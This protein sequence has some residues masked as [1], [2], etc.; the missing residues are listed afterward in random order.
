MP[1]PRSH[2]GLRLRHEGVDDLGDEILAQ[3]ERLVGVE[4]GGVQHSLLRR[5]GHRGDGAL[6]LRRGRR[7]SIP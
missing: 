1:G 2:H 3:D 6:P 5:L 4:F 7:N